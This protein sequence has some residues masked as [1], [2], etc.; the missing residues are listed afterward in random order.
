MMLLLNP[1]YP[2]YTRHVIVNKDG[3]LT[4]SDREHFLHSGFGLETAS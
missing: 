4:L 2:H 3:I 1:R